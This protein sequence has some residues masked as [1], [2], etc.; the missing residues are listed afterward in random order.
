MVNARQ[1]DR[2]GSGEV[3]QPLNLPHVHA[4]DAWWAGMLQVP[5][6]LWAKASFLLEL[7]GLLC[8]IK[9]LHS[10]EA[11]DPSKTTKTED[12]FPP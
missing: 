2:K 7:A 8:I 3:L 11:I 6:S 9:C 5:E 10:W 1:G 12:A 4:C